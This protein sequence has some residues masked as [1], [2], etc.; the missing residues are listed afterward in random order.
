MRMRSR[1]LGGF[2][3]RLMAA[4]VLAAA[5]LWGSRLMGSAAGNVTGSEYGKIIEA[6][7]QWLVE[8]LWNQA[9]P[10]GREEKAGSGREYGAVDVDPAYR[11]FWREQ[12]FYR[13]HEYLAWY[14]DET[15]GQDREE[16]SS[17]SSLGQED[18]TGA[19]RIGQ[20]QWN[21]DLA[22]GQTQPSW[23]QSG[24]SQTDGQNQMSAYPGQQAAVETL[25]GTLNRPI[26]GT[27]YQL[28]QLM[29]YDFLIKRFYS[30][31]TS[32]TAG[33]EL[34][35]AKA[36]LETD[37]SMEQDPVS[38][39]ILIYHT[40]SQETYREAESGQTVTGIGAYLAELL[41]AKGYNVYHDTTVYD[42]KDGK[43]D[44]SKAYNY[45]LEG[46]GKILEANPSIK[47]VLDIHRDGVAESL[48]LV[49]E[50][51]GKDTAQIMFFNGLSQTPEGPIQY[52]PNPHRKENLA[53]SLQLKLGAEAYYPNYARKIYLKGLRYNEHLRPRSCLIEV[54]AQ[55]N[56]YKEALNAMEPLAELLEMV[57]QGS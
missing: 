4:A 54:G 55:T 3:G 28:Q 26:T 6:A 20:N 38:P 37:L 27:T 48:H 25:A 41:E 57:L 14:G 36:F 43:M 7:G 29:D 42:L 52:L 22:A 31:H 39:Q 11:S 21:Q 46:V 35:D 33:R 40:H 15:T 24:Q 47:V 53:F 30:I 49:S 18:G 2:L 12:E 10:V 34:M 45:A 13:E 8:I 5:V 44:R 16:E 56:T 9:L 17:Q 1:S 51:D 23:N 32:T 50:V 19:G